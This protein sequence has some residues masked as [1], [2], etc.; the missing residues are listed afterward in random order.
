MKPFF[1]I[2]CG[3]FI[4][5][6]T[7]A[8]ESLVFYLE[9]DESV[10]QL[11]ISGEV[12]AIGANYRERY[13]P[14]KKISELKKTASLIML[15]NEES[16]PARIQLGDGAIRS[17]VGLPSGFAV[18]RASYDSVGRVSTAFSLVSFEG[19]VTPLPALPI[20]LVGMWASCG[21]VVYAYS[22]RAVF[23]WKLSGSDWS[24]LSLNTAVNSDAIRK[25]SNTDDRIHLVVTD[26]L[27]KAFE[28]LKAEPL[29]VEDIDSYPHPIRAHGDEL[30]W[31]VI[32]GDRSRDLRTLSKE[33]HLEEIAAP[34]NIHELLFDEDNVYIV[35]SREGGDIHKY[36]YYIMSKDDPANVDG[37]YILPDDTIHVTLWDGAIIS[38]G[39]ASQVFKTKLAQRTE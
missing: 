19:E 26:R 29:F 8:K 28:D 23:R 22:A 31:L 37:P 1:F 5:L 6:L 21:K 32:A 16:Q 12:L 3:L 30:W 35:C 39:S 18:A 25:I 4:N 7:H 17:V 13:Q 34:A 24:E 11:K 33:G 15:K 36:S 38:G 2:F 27:V 14:G 10:S 20:D 9:P